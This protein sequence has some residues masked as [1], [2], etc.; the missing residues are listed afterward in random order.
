MSLGRP[1]VMPDRV[2]VLPDFR[3]RPAVRACRRVFRRSSSDRV[4]MGVAGGI[5]ER[6]GIDPLVVRLAFVVLSLAGGVG[7]LLYVAAALVSRGPDPETQPESSPRTGAR[8]AIAVGMVVAGILL[9]LRRAGLWFGDGVVWPASLAV[10]GSAVI[11]TRG[12]EADRARWGSLM[13]R[14]PGHLTD[15]ANG[16]GVRI[17]LS[18]GAVLTVLGLTTFLT[19]NNPLALAGNAPLAVIAA[20]TGAAVI[21]GPW[22][23]R[24]ARQLTEERRERIRQEERAEMAA[25]LHDSVLQTLA[26]IV[27]AEAPGEMRTLARGQ[28]RELRAWLYGKAQRRDADLLS[29]AMD[30]TAAEVEAMHGALIDV[31]MVGDCRLDDGVRALVDACREAMINAAKHSGAAAASVYVEVEDDQVTAFVRDQGV[32]FERER[33]PGDRRGIVDSIAGRM[34]RNG[35]NALVLTRPGEGT[36]V[37]LT[38]S[39]AR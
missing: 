23:W 1:R 34:E 2:G 36:E 28:E 16:R 6:L 25:H 39:R 11:W 10:L 15:A 20:L 14:V 12:D 17:R 18:I 9:L 27:R 21:L 35:G 26:L 3:P 37:R 8:Q 30:A 19:S 31:V 32:G 4:L 24:L 33:V 13:S 38:I 7:V 29:T 5:G 22:V